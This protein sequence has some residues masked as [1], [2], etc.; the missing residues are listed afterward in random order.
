MDK[1]GVVLVGGRFDAQMR[2]VEPNDVV[3][4]REEI[5]HSFYVGDV[6]QTPQSTIIMTHRYLKTLIQCNG[7]ILWY[8]RAE[9]LSEY[10]ALS[11][12]IGGYIK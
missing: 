6:E 3:I 5:P 9:D 12:L 4:I 8:Y 2:H 1:I 10:D 11:M 7:K